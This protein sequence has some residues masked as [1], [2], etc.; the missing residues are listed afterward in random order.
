MTDLALAGSG[1]DDLVPSAGESHLS[2]E[3]LTQRAGIIFAGRVLK[4]EFPREASLEQVD[5]NNSFVQVTFQVDDGIR[6]AQ[7]GDVITIR[8]WAGIW[9]GNGNASVAN[10][11]RV[12]EKVLIFYHR[13]NASGITSPVGGANG[14]FS[15]AGRDLIRLSPE[16]KQALLRSKRLAEV[17]PTLDAAS[18]SP[19][20]GIVYSKLARALRLV[21]QETP[22]SEQ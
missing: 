14:R 22:L 5:G 18:N 8:E 10:R 11:Y 9:S 4:V 2:I 13:P 15:I 12:G 21:V 19:G 7:L 17:E 20:N 16:R 1:A 6:G 3:G